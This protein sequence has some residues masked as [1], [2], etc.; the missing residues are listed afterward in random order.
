MDAATLILTALRT[1]IF[2]LVFALGLGANFEEALYLLRRP[3]QLVRSLV[4]MNVIMPLLAVGLA[5]SFELHYAV[6]VALIALAVSP[7]PPILPKKQLKAGGS[8]HYTVGLLF[9]VALLTIVSLPLS[10][11]LVGRIFDQ[12]T[13]VSPAT[14]ALI[15]SITVIA[16]LAAGIMVRHFA[17]RFAQRMARPVSLFAMVALLV[18]VLPIVFSAW[19]AAVSLIGDGTLAA[20]VVF[21][22]A[23]LAAG[24]LLGGPDPDNRVVLALAT[25]TRHP[26]V[27]MAVAHA[28]APGEKLVLGA[29]LWY[30][31]VGLLV[32]AAYLAWRRH[33]ANAAAQV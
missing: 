14:V 33:R 13:Q 28:A 32:S 30:L 4:A 8:A 6:K 5:A 7:V 21:V 29:V 20:I 3:A 1:S 9:A 10:V 31:I 19:P 16:P 26:G 27:A 11:E 17:P 24:H 25:A 12:P 2:F 23:G 18:G 22:V 15:V